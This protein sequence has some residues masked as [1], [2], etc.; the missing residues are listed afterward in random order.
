MR[1]CTRILEFDAAH[2]ILRHESKC[3]TVHGHRYRVEITCGAAQLDNV[4]RVID[5]GAV[6]RVVGAWIDA[7][8]DHTTL[9]NPHDTALLQFVRTEYERVAGRRRPFTMPAHA[10]EPTAENIALLIYEHATRLLTTHGV[11][12]VC[13][14]VW[15][16]P[17]CYA[18]YSGGV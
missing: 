12:V 13:V 14:R 9:V 8:L 10:C 16:T 6:K 1:T 3:G 7:S 11:C 18:D 2:R 5:F 17:N 4:G 15:E